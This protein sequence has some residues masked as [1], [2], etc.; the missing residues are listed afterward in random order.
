MVLKS[1]YLRWMRISQ[2]KASF[3][4]SSIRTY[5]YLHF[6]DKQFAKRIAYVKTMP[7]LTP[8]HTLFSK[9]M[10]I[11]LSLQIASFYDGFSTLQDN[12]LSLTSELFF[13]RS[14]KD[15]F[16]DVQIERTFSCSVKWGKRF[17]WNH[18]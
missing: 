5:E 14:N 8:L 2:L 13:V 3:R 9:T 18:Q 12:F 1:K 10:R 16:L 11:I 6:D 7:K 15:G 17:C 4:F